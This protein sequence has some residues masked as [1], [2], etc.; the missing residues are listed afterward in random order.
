[1]ARENLSLGFSPKFDPY[2]SAELYIPAKTLHKAN[3]DVMHSIKRVTN[4]L[5]SSR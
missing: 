2:Q 5:F 3:L 4:V 1:M